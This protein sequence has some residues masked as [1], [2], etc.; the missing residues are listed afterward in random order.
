MLGSGT[1]DEEEE[2]VDPLR[3]DVSSMLGC[4]DLAVLISAR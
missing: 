3:A 1:T 2:G 4:V